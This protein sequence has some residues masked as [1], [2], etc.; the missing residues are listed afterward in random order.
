MMREYKIIVELPFFPLG[1]K[2]AFNDE[3]GHVY[4]VGDDGK[5]FEFPLRVGLAGYLWMLLTEGDK[6]LQGGDKQ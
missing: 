3:T 1:A 5:P 4:R 2:Y 6:Y